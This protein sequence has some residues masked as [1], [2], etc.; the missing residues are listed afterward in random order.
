MTSIE[1]AVTALRGMLVLAAGIV[2]ISWSMSPFF[3]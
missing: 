1:H 3:N 2:V